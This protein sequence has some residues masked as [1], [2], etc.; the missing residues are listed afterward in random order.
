M[1]ILNTPIER[2]EEE[3]INEA[4][5]YDRYRNMYDQIYQRSYGAAAVCCGKNI[6]E[7]M[8]K[9][10]QI[11]NALKTEYI[12]LENGTKLIYNSS[13]KPDEIYIVRKT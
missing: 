6:W 1:S 7:E 12:R 13:L 11:K 8:T 2:I 9:R 4:K 5:S 3:A 10:S